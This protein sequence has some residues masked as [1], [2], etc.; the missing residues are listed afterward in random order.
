[1]V[2]FVWVSKAYQS[3]IINKKVLSMKNQLFLEAWLS[4]DAIQVQLGEEWYNITNIK[5]CTD[6]PYHF[7][8]DYTLRIQPKHH[9]V[10]FHT[11]ERFNVCTDEESLNKINFTVFNYPEFRPEGPH[12]MLELNSGK[13]VI[14]S[15]LSPDKY[16][17]KLFTK[18]I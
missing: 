6:I 7:S 16:V 1:V 8:D 2:R 3:T 4:G 14:A 9:F 11:N 15:N 12:I 5:E 10:F 13:E 18:E 17:N